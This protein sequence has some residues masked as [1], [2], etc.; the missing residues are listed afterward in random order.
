MKAEK[1]NAT[2]ESEV[3]SIRRKLKD[4][5]EET[6]RLEDDLEELEQY[7]RK[8]SLE[9]IGVPDNAYSPTEELVVRLEEALNVS[10]KSEDIEIS[11]KLKRKHT[12]AVIVKSVTHKI[13]SRLH[14]ER[15]KLKGVK[16][17]DIF[18]S[19]AS[20][21]LEDQRI[22]LNE[23]LTSYR[24]ELFSKVIK[25]RKDNLCLDNRWEVVR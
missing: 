5:A 10:I 9:I 24:R 18:P 12:E 19:Y 13:K 17:S 14:K 15:T 20:A 8:N 4:Q 25:K 21:A 23:N 3:N 11:H 1:A 16:V 7:T 6:E 2:L 22:Y